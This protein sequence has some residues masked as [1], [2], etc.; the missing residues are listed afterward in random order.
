MFGPLVEEA[1]ARGYADGQVDGVRRA[2]EVVIE[3]FDTF[4]ADGRFLGRVRRERDA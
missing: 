2:R 4:S 3:E 1:Y